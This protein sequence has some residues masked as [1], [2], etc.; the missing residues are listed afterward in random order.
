MDFQGQFE[1]KGTKQ[2][3]A[4]IYFP[5]HESNLLFQKYFPFFPFPLEVVEVFF[6]FGAKWKLYF[7]CDYRAFCKKITN[8]KIKKDKDAKFSDGHRKR[9]RMK[10]V[11]FLVQFISD[12]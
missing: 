3:D 8:I 2:K 9:S 6:S 4:F 1:L 7:Y 10:P 11:T 12:K 5:S